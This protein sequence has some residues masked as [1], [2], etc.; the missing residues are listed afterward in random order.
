MSFVDRA[1][2]K[3]A[4][5][6][7]LCFCLWV[8]KLKVFLFFFFVFLPPKTSGISIKERQ[9]SGQMDGVEHDASP[10]TSNLPSGMCKSRLCI[11][12]NS[13]ALTD[14][15][16]TSLCSEGSRGR[17]YVNVL[18]QFIMGI[19]LILKMED[20]TCIGWEIGCFQN[21]KF[22]FIC[23]F[24]TCSSCPAVF[25]EEVELKDLNEAV[26]FFLVGLSY[27]N[28]HRGSL[29]FKCVLF[30][31]FSLFDACSLPPAPLPEVRGQSL[32]RM[33]ALC[34]V[35]GRGVDWTAVA[36]EL[37]SNMKVKW[38]AG[39]NKVSFGVP[40]FQTSQEQSGRKRPSQLLTDV[41]GRMFP[42]QTGGRRHS[43]IVPLI[44]S[45]L[46]LTG[47]SNTQVPVWDPEH[48]CSP[49]LAF[50]GLFSSVCW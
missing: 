31:L 6:F 7:L 29:R 48:P 17:E 16:S 49:T 19:S 32:K 22:I 40:P 13:A 35:S 47:S 18:Q 36:G 46:H 23:N 20:Q 37:T 12:L 45:N 43:L 50:H 39:H 5:P 27:A 26:L 21:F 1:S 33:H 44:T 4:F 11:M 25:S 38:Q 8:A 28:L 24:L 10:Q 15:Y 2:P 14:L 9:E 3:P 34:S 42:W 30:P 41:P